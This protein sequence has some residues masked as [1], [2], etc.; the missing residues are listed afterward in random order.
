MN[1]QRIYDQIINRART[2]KLEGYSEIHHIVPK[3]MGGS[4]EKQNLIELTAREHFICHWLL[5]RIHPENQGLAFAF[6]M[7]STMKSKTHRRYLPSSRVIAEAREAAA[8]AFSIRKAGVCRTEEERANMR[9]ERGPQKNPTGKRGPQKNPRQAG[10]L[11]SEQ[12]RANL[13][14]KKKPQEIR[15]CPHCGK[16]GGNAMTRWHFESCKYLKKVV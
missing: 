8:A 15:K 9:G 16:E 3:C 13:R 10:Y 7:I 1:Y 4:N 12:H 14:G 6:R 11:L 2:R 5:Y